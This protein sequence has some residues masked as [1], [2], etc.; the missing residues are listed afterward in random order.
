LIQVLCEQKCAKGGKL[1][2][3]CSTNQLAALLGNIGKHQY[4]LFLAAKAALKQK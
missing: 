4:Y 3:V 2:A 1:S